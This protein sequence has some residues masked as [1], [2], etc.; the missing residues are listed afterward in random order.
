M[1]CADK[2]AAP[3]RLGYI[4]FPGLEQPPGILAAHLIEIADGR[5]TGIFGK[6]P[7]EIIL[8][9]ARLTANIL[10]RQPLVIMGVNIA[11]GP[12]D[13]IIRPVFPGMPRFALP[14]SA[15]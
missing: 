7:A 8:G 13:R 10:Q 14:L 4:D 15:H 3:R 2:A 12:L 9:K 5:Q 1:G 11:H 6:Y